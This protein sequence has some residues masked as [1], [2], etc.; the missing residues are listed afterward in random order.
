MFRKRPGCHRADGEVV[1]LNQG[2]PDGGVRS[3]AIVARPADLPGLGWEI[4]E[5]RHW[6]TGQL[7]PTSDKSRRA[8]QAG[9]VTAWRSLTQA[10]AMRSG[11]VGGGPLCDGRGHRVVTS[12][13]AKV[14][15]GTQRPDETIV[16]EGRR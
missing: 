6:P 15:V 8:L 5:E 16:S 3:F 9:G 7:D 2:R 13:G 1:F 11:W 10:E 4:S 12:A 14:F